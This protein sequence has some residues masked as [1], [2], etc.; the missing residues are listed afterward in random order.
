MSARL[1][2]SALPPDLGRKSRRASLLSAQTRRMHR[3]L[4]LVYSFTCNLS[5]GHCIFRCR[6]CEGLTMGIARAKRYIDKA[7]QVG[8]RRIVFT[9]GEP[10]LYH[11][12]IRILIQYAAQRG[13]ETAVITNA[14]WA[15]SRNQVRQYLSDLQQRGLESITLS[16]DRYHLI[17][18]PLENLK[19]VLAVAEEI[20]LRAGVKI[21]RLPHDPV[22]QRLYLSLR[23]HSSRIRLQEILPVGR[24]SHLRPGLPLKTSSG[25]L[26]SGCSTPPVLLPDGHLMTCCNLPARDMRHHDYPFILG[27]AEMEPLPFLL[28]KRFGDPILSLLREKG[29]S[30][31]LALAAESEPGFESLRQALYHSGC[32]L[33]FQV[34][35][36][37]PDKS[38][39]YAALREGTDKQNANCGVPS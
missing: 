29:P 19:N 23:N 1:T 9:G 31:L 39:L 37:L 14:A 6:P 38:S 13:M 35:C 21:A 32:D 34:F 22:A 24:A 3:T 25:F 5:C 17:D 26:R 2:T 36:K 16:T 12:E 30:L 28:R 7:G 18:V 11:Q 33:C 4:H 8:I 15:S 20:G 27:N 10:F